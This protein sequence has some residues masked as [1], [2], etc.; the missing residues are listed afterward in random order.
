MYRDY[1]LGLYSMKGL[2][3]SVKL[4]APLGSKSCLHTSALDK[5]W[6]IVEGLGFRI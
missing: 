1:Y 3:S 5:R 4:T 2:G 6:D